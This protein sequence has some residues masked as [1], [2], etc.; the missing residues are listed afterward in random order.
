MSDGATVRVARW[1]YRAA[2][3]RGVERTGEIEAATERDAVDALRRR[4]LW[5]VSVEPLRPRATSAQEGLPVREAAARAAPSGVPDWSGARQ[6]ARRL[7]GPSEA[8]ELAVAVR[9]MAALVDAGVPVDRALGYAAGAAGTEAMKATFGRLVARVRGGAAL[10]AA[11]AAEPEI[12]RVFPPTVAAAESSGTLGR[13]LVR[14]ADHL[15]ADEA[16]RARLRSALVYPAVL[17]VASSVGVIV[18]LLV[19]VPRFATLVADVGGT[20]PL[21]T[22]TLVA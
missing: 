1:R 15:D 7:L 11:M 18:M 20:L 13:T 5:A 19:V 21:S 3:E 2:D 8:V 12:P 4:A 14:L 10:S 6:L 17:G 16:A 22:R 9:A